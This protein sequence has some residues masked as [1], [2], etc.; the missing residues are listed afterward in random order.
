M[1]TTSLP[2]S[3]QTGR[4]GTRRHRQLEPWCTSSMGSRF[5]HRPWRGSGTW[6]HRKCAD[7]CQLRRRPW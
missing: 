4:R 6:H 5:Y 2:T 1:L 3:C 7:G